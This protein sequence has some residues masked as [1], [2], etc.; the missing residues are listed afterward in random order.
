VKANE[1]LEN[2]PHAIS[3]AVHKVVMTSLDVVDHL[4]EN[5]KSPHTF[6]HG[7]ECWSSLQCRDF[8]HPIGLTPHTSP[9]STQPLPC[10]AV[11]QILNINH[12]VNIINVLDVL[13]VFNL[14][15]ILLILKSISVSALK[16]QIFKVVQL[17]HFVI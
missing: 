17:D 12:V 4:C 5:P 10:K 7:D 16:L 3:N 11:L 1:A 8:S 15:V 13:D 9:T 14:L 2:V 6:E